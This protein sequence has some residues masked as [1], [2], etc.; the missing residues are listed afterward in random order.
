MPNL[1]LNFKQVFPIA[2][3]LAESRPHYEYKD[4]N[5]TEKQLGTKLHPYSVSRL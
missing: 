1:K 4:G 3:I 5:R 2:A